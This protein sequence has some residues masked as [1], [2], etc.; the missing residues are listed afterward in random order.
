MAQEIPQELFWELVGEFVDQA[1]AMSKSQ[2]AELVGTAM[3][4][5]ASRYHTHIVARSS[6]DLEDFSSDEDNALAFFRERYEAMF[7]EN[8]ADHKENYLQYLGREA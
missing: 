1:N 5:A 4:Y 6:K 7:K 3:M 2:S 8:F